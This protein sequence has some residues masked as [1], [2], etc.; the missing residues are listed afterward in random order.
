MQVLPKDINGKNLHKTPAKSLQTSLQAQDHSSMQ[1]SD[2][3][4]Y[5]VITVASQN[6]EAGAG[7]P[8]LANQ[9]FTLKA[10]GCWSPPAAQRAVAPLCGSILDSSSLAQQRSLEP[11]G[12]DFPD[13]CGQSA[14]TRRRRP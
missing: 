7:H 9:G 5:W 11:Y 14:C 10:H 12:L 2:M 1:S 8:A 3:N 13:P 6:P 4:N